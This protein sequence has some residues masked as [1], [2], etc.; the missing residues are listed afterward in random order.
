MES[1]YFIDRRPFHDIPVP[2]N[3]ALDIFSCHEKFLARVVDEQEK[4]TINE[5]VRY[6][7]END[8]G[9]L[10]IIDGEFVK[11]AILS[12]CERGIF[13]PK[14]HLFKVLCPICMHRGFDEC[15]VCH[16]CMCEKEAGFYPDAERIQHLLDREQE[17]LKVKRGAVSE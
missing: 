16:K 13:Q 9:H 17:L 2:V 15:H 11:Q 8:I 1:K 10:R 7:Q 5:I 14:A 4:A 6:C 3:S 12:A